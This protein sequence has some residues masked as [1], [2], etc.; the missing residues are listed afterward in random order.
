MIGIIFMAILIT[1]L[2]MMV[3]PWLS[4]LVVC[5]YFLGL[6]LLQRRT[7][8]ITTE[9]DKAVLFNLAFS[10]YNMNKTCL[11]KDFKLRCKLGHLGQWIE[12]HS[13]RRKTASDAEK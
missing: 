9:M 1:I 6:Y 2:A 13:L 8:K 4:I 10:L 7:A 3:T 11:E 12:F 5:L